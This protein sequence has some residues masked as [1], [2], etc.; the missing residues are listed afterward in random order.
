MTHLIPGYLT[1]AQ[2]ARYL[3][4]SER[5]VQ[6]LQEPLQAI[7]VGGSLLW[8]DAPLKKRKRAKPGPGRPRA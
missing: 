2:A 5:R 7:K 1:T 3:G 4:V 6:Q 8:P